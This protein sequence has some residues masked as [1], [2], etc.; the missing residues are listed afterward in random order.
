MVAHKAIPRILFAGF[1]LFL[2]LIAVDARLC[3]PDVYADEKNYRRLVIPGDPHLPGKEIPAKESVIKTINSWDDVD[4]V[5]VLGDICFELGTSQEYA[6]AKQFFSQLKKPVYFINGNHDYI[7]DDFLDSKGRKRKAYSGNREK[8]LK[9]F[10]ET[11]NLPE[12]YYT[13]KVGNYLLFFL[14]IDELGS[15]DLARISQGQLDWLRSELDRNKK[16]PTIVFFHAP[17]EGTLQTYNKDVNTPSFVVQPKDKVRELILRNPQL[18]L[19]VSGHT[20]TPATNDSYASE[21]NFYEKQ[22]TNIHNCDMNRGTIW[23]NSLYLYPDKVSVRT[24]NHKRGAWMD[25]L[26]RTI[27]PPS[28]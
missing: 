8:K 14:P 11:F 6:Y 5:V 27:I 2:V 7:Y 20:H 26:E 19:W 28:T 13:T 10:K 23:T 16:L 24:F 15:S 25:N 4:M 1:I 18:F 21:I 17:L 12:L 22:V 3:T 9:L